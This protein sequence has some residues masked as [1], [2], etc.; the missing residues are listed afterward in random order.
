[1]QQQNQTCN[2]ITNN[3]Q[4]N[5]LEKNFVYI[6]KMCESCFKNCRYILMFIM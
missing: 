6:N 1:M 3:L 2:K 5:K 4:T